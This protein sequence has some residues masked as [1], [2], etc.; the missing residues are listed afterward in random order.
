M[1]LT[2]RDMLLTER[3][4]SLT[5]RDILPVAKRYALRRDMSLTGR[6]ILPVAKRYALR[7]DMPLM[8][9][10]MSL[11]GVGIGKN[12]LNYK[13]FPEKVIKGYFYNLTI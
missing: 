4:M 3:D 8:E 10:D 13:T 7:R 9:R 6:D 1:L 2:E 12:T 5:G 11:T